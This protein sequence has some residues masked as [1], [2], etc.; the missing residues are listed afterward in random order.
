MSK[1]HLPTLLLTAILVLAA[2]LRLW[3][4]GA[5]EFKYDEA[6][7]SNLAAQF[8]DTGVPPLRGMG[9]STGIDNPPMAIYLM[10]LPVLLSRDPLLVTAFVAVVNVVG[11][12]GCYWLGRRYW[13]SGVG[14]LAALLLAV[15]PWA[16]F[17]SRKVW[18]QNLLLPCVILFFALLYA[19]FVDRVRWALSGAIFSALTTLP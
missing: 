4:L 18:A 1:R 16:T 13:G 15:S 17:Y 5:T 3:N 10:S 2:F 14:L 7:V 11:V 8:I 9:S 12:W 6:R 19:W